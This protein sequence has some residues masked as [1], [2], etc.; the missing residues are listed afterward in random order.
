MKDFAL[1][2]HDRRIASSE[3]QLLINVPVNF[4]DTWSMFIWLMN[5]DEDIFEYSSDRWLEFFGHMFDCITIQ[6]PHNDVAL[7]T[8]RKIDVDIKRAIRNAEKYAAEYGPKA[9]T[10]SS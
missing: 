8:L 7:E 9:S 3:I 1:W 2:L 10:S 5:S 4:M 6:T